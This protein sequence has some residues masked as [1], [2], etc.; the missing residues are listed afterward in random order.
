MAK[1]GVLAFVLVGGLILGLA[2]EH[3]VQAA[4]RIVE[5]KVPG[6]V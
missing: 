1:K 3:T 2:A 4:E 5:L 6:C